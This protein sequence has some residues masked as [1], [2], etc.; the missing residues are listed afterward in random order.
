VLAE[1]IASQLGKRVLLIDRRPHIGGNAYDEINEAGVCVHRYGPHIF[2]T[3]SSKV[4]AYLSQFTA[5]RPYEH[6]VLASV[7]DLLVPMPIN[8]LTLNLLYG[9]NLSSDAEA[10]AYLAGVAEPVESV[11]TS[12]DV[13][14]SRVGRAL[15]ETFFRGYTRKQWGVDPAKLDHSVAARVPA[16]VTLDDRY[17][18]DSFQAMP[19]KGYT[20]ML[21]NMLDHDGVTI[22]LGTDF[23]DLPAEGIA[24]RVVFTGA[25]D[26]Y[27][28]RRYGPLPYRSLEFRHQTFDQPWFQTV[29]TVNYPDEAAPYTR[30]TEFKH[31]TGQVVNRTTIAYEFPR[32]EGDPYYPVPTP[33]SRALFER[34]R[35]LS[36]DRPD[37]LFT[38]RLG[39]YRYYN[40]DQVVGQALAAF[41]K[42]AS[43]AWV[44]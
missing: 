11:R 21:E 23:R 24:K 42:L 15:Y 35:A 43:V 22:A 16:R 39:S 34:Y 17:F 1:R 12:E 5:W 37:V 25:I 8:R 10:E 33:E 18:T 28:G 19:S 13:V 32:D 31:L 41:R 20:A 9:M 14:V 40:M 2:H 7:G 26:E 30:I 38:G 29:G 3:N 36:R 27:F 6:R 4:V 44:D